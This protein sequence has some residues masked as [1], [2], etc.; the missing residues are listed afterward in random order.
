MGVVYEAYDHET[1]AIVALKTLLCAEPEALLRFKNEFRALADLQ[2]PN[3]L[4]LG[5]LCCERGQWFFTM[6][7]VHGGDFQ[8]YV[9]PDDAARGALRR[10]DGATQPVN[11]GDAA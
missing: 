7:L 8:D 2:H 4:R 9:R 10:D 3:L 1:D 11:L 5:E 6:E